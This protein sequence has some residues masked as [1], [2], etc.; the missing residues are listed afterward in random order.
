MMSILF[1]DIL[2]LQFNIFKFAISLVHAK[3]TMSE[4]DKLK[5]YDD[6]I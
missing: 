6:A 3:D 4:N 1:N 2:Q 5:I